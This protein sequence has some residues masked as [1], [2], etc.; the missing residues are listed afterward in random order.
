MTAHRS[1]PLSA[2]YDNLIPCDRHEFPFVDRFSQFGV[3][4]E[5]GRPLGPGEMQ[6]RS[7]FQPQAV[8]A[9]LLTLWVDHGGQRVPVTR[10]E[11]R[12]RPWVA[13]ESGRHEL[14]S[15]TVA[16]Q[17][18]HA[19]ADELT[20]VSRFRLTC[21]G[22]RTPS[23]RLAWRGALCADSSRP[24]E[25]RDYGCSETERRLAWAEVAGTR[26]T[27]GLVNAGGDVFLPEPRV[28]IEARG[29]SVHAGLVDPTTDAL[30]PPREGRVRAEPGATLRYGF[31]A[32]LPELGAGEG[33]DFVFV[34]RLSVATWRERDPGWAELPGAPDVDA[35][36][37]RNHAAFGERATLVEPRAQ[38]S[39]RPS[40][41]RRAAWALLRTGYQGR[42][43][44]GE[45]GDRVASTCV[46]VGGGFTHIFFW[47][48]LFASVA[49][50]DFDAGFARGAIESV[51]MRQTPEGYCPEHVFNY[52][53][54][55]GHVIGAPQAPVAAWA[56]SRYL[57]R[58]PEDRGFLA[59]IMPAL[60]RNFS[61]WSR[62][63]DRD[64][65]GLAEWTWT[66]QTADTSPLYDEFKTSRAGCVHLPPIAS[67]QLNSFLYRDAL[68]LAGLCERL[69]RGAES[70]GYRADARRRQ[71]ALMRWC[72]VPEE[73]RFWDYNH[74]TRRH[75]RVRTFYLFWPIW[76][77]MDVPAET[78]R[79]LI[80]NVLLD[81][82]QFFG[83][84]P[85]PSVAYDEPS[86][87]NGSYTA[88]DGRA[89]WRGRAW[90]QISYWLIEML[91]R[92]GYVR[93]AD[94]AARRFLAAY[95]REPS[96]PEHLSTDPN[97]YH[98]GGFKDYNWGAAAYYL[99]A[100]GAH[101]E[102]AAWEAGLP[103]EG[104]AEPSRETGQPRS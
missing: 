60:E 5:T 38:A 87:Y 47:D 45:L 72:H 24:S 16:V 92:E 22:G 9:P 56:V 13:E 40:R 29:L 71:A 100:T 64:R 46:P 84:V 86:Y 58:R 32:P 97:D 65:D 15:A 12:S 2:H 74:A 104:R 28:R 36:A 8:A 89:W 69:G 68:L 7:M 70:E 27:G 85:F 20:L 25:L 39:R 77:G 76:A 83:P 62:L 93:E 61:Y 101:R 11:L 44:H 54:E 63:G 94:E 95:D 82:R 73:R 80:E 31:E 53:I 10:R 35:I 19:Y 78:K 26:V 42:T 6:V 41:V 23:V 99:L 37:A 90:P 3:V 21:V 43:G 66:G 81:P 67:V 1:E 49:L 4:F 79:D 88:P 103:G 50:A 34:T 51:F 55:P 18:T 91:V 96:F 17:A 30:L 102:A 14:G 98:A 75:R 57:R 52:W 59:S 48:A 33:I